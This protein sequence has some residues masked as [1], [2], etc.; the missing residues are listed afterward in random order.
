MKIAGFL[1]F[2]ALA[3]VSCAQEVTKKVFFDIEI[4]GKFEGKYPTSYI[5]HII[6]IPLSLVTERDF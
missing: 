3:G 2:F 5:S 6:M 1:T 4:D